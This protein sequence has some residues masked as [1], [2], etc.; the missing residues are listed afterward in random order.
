MWS[1]KTASPEINFN[2]SGDGD[3]LEQNL[4]RSKP[5]TEEIASDFSSI[6]PG[7]DAIARRAEQLGKQFANNPEMLNQLG[8]I[9]R[10]IHNRTHP[11]ENSMSDHMRA[12]N[13]LTS[14]Y[15]H[16]DSLDA[17]HFLT[18]TEFETAKIQHGYKPTYL[19]SKTASEDPKDPEDPEVDAMHPSWYPYVPGRPEYRSPT[20]EVCGCGNQASG[21]DALGNPAC[22]EHDV[23]AELERHYKEHPEDR[24]KPKSAEEQARDMVGFIR[25]TLKKNMEDPSNMLPTPREQASLDQQGAKLRDESE[26]AGKVPSICNICLKP[27]E[28]AV[29]D[30]HSNHQECDRTRNEAWSR[31]S[32]LVQD[33]YDWPNEHSEGARVLLGEEGVRSP[34][35]REFLDRAMRTPTDEELR[36]AY[37]GARTDKLGSSW[38][39]RYATSKIAGVLDCPCGQGAS[40]QRAGKTLTG[41]LDHRSLYEPEHPEFPEHN[42]HVRTGINNLILMH[43]RAS[44]E[45]GDEIHRG[46]PVSESHRDHMHAH[47]DIIGNL[48]G[49]LQNPVPFS[50]WTA[51]E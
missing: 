33:E 12:L 41:L 28:N 27:N 13:G 40:I 47:L 48:F 6:N 9:L 14:G 5:L 45:H 24:P 42:E 43:T 19:G 3:G 4:E 36:A 8:Q 35:H 29:P 38:A 11:N 39:T 18:P 34:E 16:N 22:H 15:S 44:D 17:Y 51:Y 25:D 23:R 37:P 30:R 26:I 46:S 2:L 10:G 20:G 50:S 31:L 32:P 1:R 7:M 49:E 21:K